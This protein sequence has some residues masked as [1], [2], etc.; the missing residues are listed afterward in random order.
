MVGWVVRPRCASMWSWPAGASREPIGRRARASA[1]HA[2]SCRVEA[3]TRIGVDETTDWRSEAGGQSRRRGASSRLWRAVTSPGLPYRGEAARSGAGG[4]RECCAARPCAVPAR[5][6]GGYVLLRV[7]ADAVLLLRG[8]G[9]RGAPLRRRLRP[10]GARRAGADARQGRRG[11]P[12]TRGQWT[13][14]LARPRPE[15]PV[16]AR[17][18]GGR[19]EGLRP[20]RGRVGQRRGGP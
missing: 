20:R 8:R 7:H 14:M 4:W 18:G 6:R 13:R 10:G 16:W 15:S 5:P 9:A 17:R 2:W 11:G 3:R 19:S 12:Q 1:G